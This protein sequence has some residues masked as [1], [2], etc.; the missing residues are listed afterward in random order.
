M[1]GEL[2]TSSDRRNDDQEALALDRG[3]DVQPAA[4]HRAASPITLVDNQV[5]IDNAPFNS[6]GAEDGL[7]SGNYGL[8]FPTFIDIPYAIFDFGATG[9]VSSATLTWNFIELYGGSGP[10]SIS[11][12]VGSDAS[13]TIS[14]G[15]RFMGAPIDTFTYS[16]GEL[17]SYDVT[18]L[19]NTALLSGQYFAARLEATAAPGTLAGYY[20][21]QFEEPALTA[22]AGAAAVP[23]PASLLLLGVGGLGL[24]AKLRRRKQENS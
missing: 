6:V 4:C 12:Y 14:T 23:E 19:V 3:P 5:I 2:E 8:N 20:G 16:G 15:D 1:R 17:R 24:I 18:A 7:G 21:G 11:L 9:S 10:A 22:T 13:G